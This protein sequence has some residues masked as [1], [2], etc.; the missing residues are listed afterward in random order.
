[1]AI[2]LLI[3]NICSIPS[4]SAQLSFEKEL[5]ASS[6]DVGF[7]LSWSTLSEGNNQYFVVERALDVT[8]EIKWRNIFGIKW[9]DFVYLSLSNN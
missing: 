4:L 7:I 1:M 2:S 8:F 3:L 5:S 6:S 9:R